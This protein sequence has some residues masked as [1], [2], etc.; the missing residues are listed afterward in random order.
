MCWAV[1]TF[2]KGYQSRTDI[3]KDEKCGL[4]ADS[5]SIVV[6]GRKHFSQLLNGQS[7]NHKAEPLVPEPNVFEVQMVIVKLKRHK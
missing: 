1:N 7:F 3:V 2:K 5:Y 6:M 4:V